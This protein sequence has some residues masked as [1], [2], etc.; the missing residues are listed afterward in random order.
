MK[1]STPGILARSGRWT[2]AVLTLTAAVTLAGCGGSN[3]DIASG[4][5]PDPVALN[6][7]LAYIKRPVPDF[8]SGM[9]TQ[10]DPDTREL[11]PVLPCGGG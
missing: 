11:L 6:F 9:M 4:Q 10:V 8:T 3:V 7:A 5:D 2:H 1:T